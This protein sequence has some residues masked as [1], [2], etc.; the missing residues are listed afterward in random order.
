MSVLIPYAHKIYMFKA[1]W[2]FLESNAEKKY[3][4]F[5]PSILSQFCTCLVKSDQCGLGAAW[6]LRWA[7]KQ[8]PPLA[9]SGQISEKVCRNNRAQGRFVN[10]PLEK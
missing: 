6:V 5:Q 8:T 2:S 10:C 3:A 9:H 4:K 1:T 7:V